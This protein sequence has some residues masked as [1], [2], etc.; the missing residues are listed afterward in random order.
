MVSVFSIAVPSVLAAVMAPAVLLAS[1]SAPDTPVSDRVPAECVMF[2]DEPRE[3][4][5]DVCV[6]FCTEPAPPPASEGC[7]LFCELDRRSDDWG[8]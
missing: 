3:H 2:C 1:A 6:M 5:P 4:A 7:R 8:M